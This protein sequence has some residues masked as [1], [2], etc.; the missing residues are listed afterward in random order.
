MLV[1][2]HHPKERLDLPL[3]LLKVALTFTF[4]WSTDIIAVHHMVKK[5]HR[6][7]KEMTFLLHQLQVQVTKDTDHNPRK[8]HGAVAQALGKPIILIQA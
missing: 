6:P 1:I 3:L 2:Q 8:G 5:S 7:A 4:S